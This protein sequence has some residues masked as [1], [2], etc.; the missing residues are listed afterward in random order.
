MEPSPPDNGLAE[1]V[2]GIRLL[3]LDV[4]G[5]LTDGTIY[6]GPEGEDFK[7]FNVHD[8]MG[9]LLA[10]QNYAL[11]SVL[12]TGKPSRAV[13]KRAEQ[14]GIRVFPT[15]AL[16][17]LVGLHL[18]H[19]TMGVPLHEMAYMGDDVPDIP[20]L[21]AVGL[22]LCPRSAM[23]EVKQH[24]G[25]VVPLDGGHGAVRAAIDWMLAYRPV[26]TKEEADA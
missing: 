26:E 23:A 9:I 7:Q 14:L 11:D 1:R 17:K 18:V 12:L 19:D 2:R 22:A 10:R 5:V 8:G 6:V 16:N 13:D 21:D 15:P 20:V 4:D 3:V 24:A 25:Y